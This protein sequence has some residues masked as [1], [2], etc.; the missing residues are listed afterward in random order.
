MC[1]YMVVH[2]GP[3]LL[4]FLKILHFSTP[5]FAIEHS[6]G[7]KHEKLTTVDGYRMFCDTLLV[8]SRFVMLG[9]SSLMIY[10]KIQRNALLR[11]VHNR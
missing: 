8:K 9:R 6:N 10:G 3:G 4:H 2:E 7:G 5:L 1:L 11:S